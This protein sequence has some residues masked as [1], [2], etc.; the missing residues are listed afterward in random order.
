MNKKLCFKSLLQ[1]VLIAKI[2]LDKTEFV[3]YS[4]YCFNYEISYLSNFNTKILSL[5]KVKTVT[6]KVVVSLKCQI[7]QLLKGQSSGITKK[8]A[9]EYP[10]KVQLAKSLVH[11][12]LVVDNY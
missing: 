2:F 4:L 11:Q 10:S 5:I 8:D 3:I 12:V 7:K 9:F 6:F 1:T